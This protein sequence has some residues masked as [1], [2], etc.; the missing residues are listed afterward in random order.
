MFCREA[1]NKIARLELSLKI[2]EK[3]LRFL[4]EAEPHEPDTEYSCM[5]CDMGDAGYSS[6]G[7][8][9]HDDKANCCCPVSNAMTALKNIQKLREM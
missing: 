1:K 8:G 2:A 9:Y 3:S 7:D 4:I 6:K 5:Y